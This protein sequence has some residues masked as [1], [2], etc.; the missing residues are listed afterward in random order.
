MQTFRSKCARLGA[1]GAAAVLSLTGLTVMSASP[2]SAAPLP[3]PTAQ[4][5]TFAGPTGFAQ[6]SLLGAADS[7]PTAPQGSDFPIA[8]PGGSQAVPTSQSG[9][10]VNFISN[11]NQYYEIPSGSTFVSASAS[12]PITWAGG[13]NPSLPPSGSAPE[14]IID[15]TS[16]AVTGCDAS[17]NAPPSTTG[18][19]FSGFAGPN[20]TFP[21]LLVS[22]G[23]A[24]I[25][26]GA[27]L[28]TPTTTVNLTASGAVGTVLDWAQFEFK[29]AANITLFGNS[30]NAVI[31]GWPSA[32][33]YS[34]T[35]SPPC[36]GL[37]SGT[38]PS[39]PPQTSVPLTA[40]LNYGP[41][42]VLTSTTISA[43][44]PFIN[45]TN[46]QPINSTATGVTINVS[47]AN[48]P[49]NLTAG[50][51]AWSGCPSPALCNDV[52]TFT[53]SATG[54]LTGTILFGP[55]EQLPSS[56]SA[57]TLS[58]T[59]TSGTTTANTQVTVNPFQ[60]FQT[61]CSIGT[62]HLATCTINQ[63][64]S[65]TV[66]G[67]SLTISEVQTG[68]ANP[69]NSAVVLSP[70]TLGITGPTCPAVPGTACNNQQFAQAQGLLNT[71]VV[72]DNR[73][74]LGGW[75]VTGQLG[76]DFQNET[77]HGP[78]LDNVIPAD[79]LTWQ[80]AVA[81]ETP[82]SLPG[83]NA[84]I[85]G[86]PDQTPPPP[87]IP[88]A[89]T[90]PSGLP[91]TTGTAGGAGGNGTGAPVGSL[92]SPVSAPAEV[93]PGPVAVLNNPALSPDM[94]CET[95]GGGPGGGG[96][97]LCSAGMSLAVP[98]YVAS[99]TYSATMNIVVIGF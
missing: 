31:D 25:P 84:N 76:G 13:T 59:A 35:T 16:A 26:A 15:C 38:P 97:F 20:P 45:V 43:P 73:G 57:I 67:T 22:T 24:Q 8:I 80:P 86:C 96:G 52:G 30:I 85:P 71:V 88:L 47:G 55:N 41:P 28:T 6:Q 27:V 66:I 48:W 54:A 91:S 93:V 17:N 37:T 23:S 39:C 11:T 44:A 69:S 49:I 72:S 62:A 98:P 53:T 83:N 40:S 64:V 19:V 18:G 78:T 21:Y 10:A 29:T 46:V 42:P 70:V 87:S 51:L 89:C 2:A 92:T 68:P 58:L 75:T 50:S 63:V 77:P 34:T 56:Q 33:L 14:T 3:V 9:V 12:G 94:L 79:F 74:T 36:D 82:G 61:A 1:V 81:L 95:V 4:N 60:S 99:G 90:G 32:G 65:A 7:Q 5:F